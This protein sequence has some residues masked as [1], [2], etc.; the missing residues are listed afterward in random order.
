M[1]PVNIW[2]LLIVAFYDVTS[3]DVTCTTCLYAFHVMFRKYAHRSSV[4]GYL[5]P[6]L[7]LQ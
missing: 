2:H 4:L 3:Y 5:N 7:T 6:L 1:F